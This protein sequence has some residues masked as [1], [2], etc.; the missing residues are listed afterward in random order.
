LLREYKL[1]L[2]IGEDYIA[3]YEEYYVIIMFKKIYM[4]I[5]I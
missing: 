2:F 3:Q 4:H 5:I 1:C